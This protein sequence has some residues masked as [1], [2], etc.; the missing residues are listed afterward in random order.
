MNIGTFKI[1]DSTGR[2][3]VSGKDVARDI[4]KL[5]KICSGGTYLDCVLE[6]RRL[7]TLTKEYARILKIPELEHFDTFVD[8]VRSEDPMWQE[9]LDASE[10]D[11]LSE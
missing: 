11:M 3:Y 5:P 7:T 4:R 9:I 1:I 2:R 6:H 10:D 8:A